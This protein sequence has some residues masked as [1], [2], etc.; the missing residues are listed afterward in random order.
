MGH[1]QIVIHHLSKTYRVPERAAG[2][3]AALKS[4]IHRAHRDVHAV[5]DISFE[6]DTGE[7]VGAV[8]TKYPTL[9]EHITLRVE[10]MVG[11]LHGPVYV[12]RRFLV[13]CYR[14]P[15]NCWYL[16]EPNV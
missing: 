11:A 12:Y 1:M 10:A 16:K 6:I 2:L 7:S 4:V 8:L 9:C 13:R 14:D 15:Y 5:R 3:H